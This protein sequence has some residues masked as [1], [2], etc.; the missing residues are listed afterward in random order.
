LRKIRKAKWLNDKALTWLGT[1]DLQADAIFDLKTDD[2][3]LSVWHVEDDKS[4]L[5]VVIAALSTTSD[6][7]SNLDYVLVE[8]SVFAKAG[9]KVIHTRG[10]TV[11][12]EANKWHRDL[13]ELSA[14]SLINTALLIASQRSE[15]KRLL[16]KQVLSLLQ[17]KIMAGEIKTAE[18][19]EKLR[20]KI[21]QSPQ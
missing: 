15:M 21:E 10:K 12:D 3:A 6:N 9:L 5:Q 20:G 1:D 16:P 13:V 4:N 17:E 2:N 14:K 8:Q 7:L 18:L 11:Y 19:K